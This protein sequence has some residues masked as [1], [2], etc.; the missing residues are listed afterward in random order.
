MPRPDK[1]NWPT[2]HVNMIFITNAALVLVLPTSVNYLPL[3]PH[4]GKPILTTYLPN[5][6]AKIQ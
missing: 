3:M 6:F 5:A 1:P 2:M 4:A